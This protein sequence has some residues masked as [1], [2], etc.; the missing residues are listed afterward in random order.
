MIIFEIKFNKAEGFIKKINRWAGY[1]LRPRMQDQR[2][3]FEKSPSG[4]LGANLTS[5]HSAL[6]SPFL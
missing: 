5:C 2:K 3:C 1:L 4:D 6:L